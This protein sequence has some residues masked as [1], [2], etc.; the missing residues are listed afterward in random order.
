V[1]GI[2]EA[3]RRSPVYHWPV[4]AVLL[5]ILLGL[6]QAAQTGTVVGVVKP[7]DNAKTLQDARVVLLPPKYV[8]ARDKQV[9]TRLDN[10]WEI[11]KPEFV[12]R[13][14]SFTDFERAAQIEAFR[15]VTSNMRRELGDSASKLMK[16]V[17]P[18]GQFEFSGIAFGTYQLLVLATLNGQEVIWSKSVEVRTGI[19][20][21]VELGKPVS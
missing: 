2:Y 18:S 15:S 14:E 4:F 5:S 17:S 16:N 19:P 20:I 6:A 10:Y 8:E 13:K 7:P 11:F 12:A 3:K 21:F 9:Q 1:E